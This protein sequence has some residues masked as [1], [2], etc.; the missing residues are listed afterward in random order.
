VKLTWKFTIFYLFWSFYRFFKK[1]TAPITVYGFDQ[2][3]KP[4]IDRTLGPPIIV[5]LWSRAKMTLLP[6]KK[7][8]FYIVFYNSGS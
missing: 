3:N 5:T 8:S 2:S 1:M 6:G 4:E 7:F